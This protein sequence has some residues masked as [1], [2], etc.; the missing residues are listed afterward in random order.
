MASSEPKTLDIRTRR[1]WRTWLR[2]H[3][4]T[5]TAV[6]LIFHKLHTAVECL[7]YEDAIEEAL[8]FGWVDSLVKRLDEDRFARKFTPRKPNSKWSTINRRRYEKVK[9][10]GLLEPPGLARSPTSRSGDAPIVD[11][12]KPPADFKRALKENPAALARYNGLASSYRRGIL[13]WIGTAK[14]EETRQ[15]RIRQVIDK[16]ASGQKL[17]LQ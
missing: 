11:V 7:E 8:C 10:L 1:A 14:K 15:K 3:H 2:K 6:W 9:S 16:L 5:T 4:A 17:G 12:A 13:G